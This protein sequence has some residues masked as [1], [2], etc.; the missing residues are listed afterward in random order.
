MVPAFGKDKKPVLSLYLGCFAF[1]GVLIAAS[2][3]GSHDGHDGDAGD[4]GDGGGAH[5]ALL[6][7]LSFRFWVFALG[8]FGLTGALLTWLGGGLAVTAALAG[9]TGVG[10][11]YGASRLLGSLSRS[12]VGLLP[13]SSAHVGREGKLLLPVGKGRR[14]KIRLSIGGISNDLVAET[15]MD[16]A[17][18]AGSTVLVVGIRG[19]SAVVAK[20]P[21]ALPS[22]SKETP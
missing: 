13:P 15:D 3:F 16:E 6:P 4:H 18:P 12:T 8:F 19:T 10:S 14:G 7:L 20:S 11:G 22:A 9:L 2:L 5:H 1:G 17:L 21:V